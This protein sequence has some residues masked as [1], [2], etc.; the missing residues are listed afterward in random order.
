MNNEKKNETM[1]HTNLPESC[2]QCRA[3]SGIAQD[4]KGVKTSLHCIKETSKEDHEHLWKTIH[5]HHKE[6]GD[7]MKTKISVRIF[8]AAFA[9]IVTLAITVSGFQWA[10]I[11][12]GDEL[13]REFQ[14]EI[15]EKVN[16]IMQDITVIK[17]LAI[18][19][20]GGKK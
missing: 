18:E 16:E 4:M 19:N 13:D 2:P 5:A 15:N 1:K 6:T 20:N 8:V 9:L 11:S 7:D 14:K 17:A 12:K 10:A 3:H